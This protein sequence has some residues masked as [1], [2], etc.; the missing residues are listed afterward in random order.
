M[1]VLL[2]DFHFADGTAGEHNILTKTLIE[3]LSELSTNARNVNAKEIKIVFLGDIFDLL[4]TEKWFD[5]PMNHRPWGVKTIDDMVK[6]EQHANVIMDAIINHKENAN[7]FE[8][9]SMSLKERFGF[10]VEPEKIYIVGNHDRLCAQL[11]S[12]YSKAIKALG[13]SNTK[14]KHYYKDKTYGV[15]ARHGHEFDGFNYE[16]SICF[17]NDDYLKMPIGDAVTTELIARMPYTVMRHE[18]V[19]NLPEE[20]K[21]TLKRNLQ[22]IESVRPLASTIDWLF[23]KVKADAWL[24][25]IVNDCIKKVVRDFKK[26]DFVKNWIKTHHKP[27][28]LF[29]NANLIRMALFLLSTLNLKQIQKILKIADIVTVKYRDPLLKGAMS[30]LDRLGPD[31]YYIS[32][33]HTHM[34]VQIPIKVDDSVKGKQRDLFYINTGTWVDKYQGAVQKGFINWNYITYTIFY[35]VKEAQHTDVDDVDFPLFETWNGAL[36]KEKS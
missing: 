35:S 18:K 24:G 14:V 34:P 17:T 29:D 11:P 36:K 28:H 19:R 20:D 13:A 33:G 12:I 15:F 10:P 26:I 32:L 4:R 30:K 16:G 7:T 5:V 22:E 8:L 2:S 27:F 9:L 25:G 23:Y 21:A 31:F 1:L 6:M 3:I